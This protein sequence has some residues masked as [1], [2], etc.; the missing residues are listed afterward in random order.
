MASK[1]LLHNFKAGERLQAAQ[2]Q[3]MKI[4]LESIG[5][6]APVRDLE[7]NQVASEDADI[8]EDDALENSTPGGAAEVWAFQAKATR[9]E[10]I[11]DADD[12]DTY[13]DISQPVTL[14]LRRPDGVRIQLILEA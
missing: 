3:D 11:E 7:A 9:Q 10:R 14:T 6:A 1:P 13:L 5:R 4:Y 2:L 12:S 8:K